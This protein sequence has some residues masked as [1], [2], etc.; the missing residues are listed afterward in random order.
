[1]LGE[2]S[3]HDDGLFVLFLLL[4]RWLAGGLGG[5]KSQSTLLLLQLQLHFDG[6]VR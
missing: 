1:M 5:G 6:L 4:V 3:N 2:S